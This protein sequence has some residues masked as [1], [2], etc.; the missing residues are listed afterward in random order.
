[1]PTSW[2]ARTVESWSS[3]TRPRWWGGGAP[4]GAAASSA[5]ANSAPA[6]NGA[7]GMADSRGGARDVSR[8]QAI[9]NECGPPDASAPGGPRKIFSTGPSAHGLSSSGCRSGRDRQDAALL[10][11]RDDQ[12]GRRILL[13]RPQAEREAL[14]ILVARLELERDLRRAR[15][16][17]QRE[18][19]LELLVEREGDLV[20]AGRHLRRAEVHR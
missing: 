19:P 20:G 7:S 18:L 16:A 4:C 14:A 13:A 17:G 12:L 5:P 8:Q 9:G 15:L 10:A 6:R 2:S 11:E 3:E 1:M